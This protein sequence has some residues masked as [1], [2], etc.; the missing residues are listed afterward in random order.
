MTR[1]YILSNGAVADLQDITRY[2]LT[3]WGEAQ[4]R[5]YI[6]ELE[7]KAEALALREGIFKDM[8]FILPELRMAASGNHYIFCMPQKNAPAIILAILHE[9][10]DILVRLRNRLN[11][12]T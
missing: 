9:R 3:N 1:P 10:M 2:T 8:G 11:A 4:C 6:A 7:T 5:T 12:K